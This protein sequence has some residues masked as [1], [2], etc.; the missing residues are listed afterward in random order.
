MGEP[1]VDMLAE[2]LRE[3]MA[4][5]DQP[6]LTLTSDSMAPLLRTGDQIRIAPAAVD[7][8]QPGDIV[9]FID[10]SDAVQLMTHRFWGSVRQAD[11]TLIVTRGDRPL[12]FDRP[13]GA[14][15][16][17]G[18]A[19][20]RLRDGR[21]LRLDTGSGA[22]LNR[23]LA[24]LAGRDIAQLAGVEY[25]ELAR[26]V[27]AVVAD[28]AGSDAAGNRTPHPVQRLVHRTLF[29]A[30]FLLTGAAGLFDRS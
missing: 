11:Q 14:G 23:R 13:F 20:A 24:G 6:A 2:L 10:D 3:S 26:I 1:D 16:L 15:R 8:L 27:A 4:R 9:T 5:G 22:R 28:P 7:A 18:R 21:E 17:V 12:W 19:V 29:A 25:A 30:G